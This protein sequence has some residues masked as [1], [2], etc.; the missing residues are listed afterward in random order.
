ML[1]EFVCLNG[2]FIKAKDAKISLDNIEFSYG[3][4]VY[5]NIRLRNGKAYFLREHIERLFKSAEVIGLKHDFVNNQIVEWLNDLIAKNKVESA[6]V[7]MLLIGGV[8]P[9]LYIM[10]LAPQ[11]PD[12]KIYRDGVSVTSYNYERFLPEAKTLNMLPS[13]MAFK[14][15]QKAGDYDALFVDNIGNVVEGTRSNFFVIKNKTLYTPPVEK[16]LDGVTRRT[17][18]ACAKENGYRVAEKDIKLKNI[19]KYDGAFLTNTSAKIVPIRTIDSKSFALV[20]EEIK[21]LIKLYN[22]WIG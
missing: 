4:G 1:G 16:V 22:E 19:L 10:L 15:A 12:K 5:E 13:Y 20:D 18:I 2:Q 8:E 9:Q 7:K 21:K 6:N 17:V 3:F 14:Q 11:Y